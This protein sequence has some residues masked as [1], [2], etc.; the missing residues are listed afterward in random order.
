[1]TATE[2]HYKIVPTPMRRSNCTAGVGMPNVETRGCCGGG[3]GVATGQFVRRVRAKLP[4]KG[5][6]RS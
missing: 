5:I 2:T 1:M 6:I 3:G 4:S